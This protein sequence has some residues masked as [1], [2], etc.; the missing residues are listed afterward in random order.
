MTKPAP[1][2]I[3]LFKTLPSKLILKKS[4]AEAPDKRGSINLEP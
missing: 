3:S 4:R 2:D 1:S